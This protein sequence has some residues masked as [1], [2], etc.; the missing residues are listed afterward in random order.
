MF[1]KS[2]RFYDA[3]YSAADKDYKIEAE[4]AHQII[5]QKKR[6]PGNSLL[7]VACGTGLHASHFRKYY[8]V[9]GLDLDAEMLAVASDRYAGIPFH[10]ADMSDFDLGKQF[11][12]ITCLFSS[13]GYVKTK[14]RLNQAIQTMARHLVPGGVLIVEPWF[15]PEQWKTGRV[16]ALFV[17]QPDI[18]ISRM[19]ISE[20]NGNLSFFVFHYMVATSQGV[21]Y[22]TE[23]HE[24][25][26]FAHEEYLGAFQEAGLEVSHDPEGL[27]GR[28][29][30]IGIKLAP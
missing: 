30:Y 8:L 7:E 18:K 2:A 15:T 22:F 24:L 1:S 13:V 11:D 21:E 17:D 9:E 3:V 14:A 27:D 20:A 26:L 23:R 19:N 16:S 4:K 12:V 6:S 29:L 28:G 25:G 10:H 5:E